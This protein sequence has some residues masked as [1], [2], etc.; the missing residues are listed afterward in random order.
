MLTTVCVNLLF[1]AVFGVLDLAGK[2]P[3]NEFKKIFKCPLNPYWELKV[4]F[5]VL[6]MI[7]FLLVSPIWYITFTNIR[8]GATTFQRYGYLRARSADPHGNFKVTDQM[9]ESFIDSSINNPIVI[10]CR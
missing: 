8:I 10:C 4:V 2:L 5:V 7:V 9:T 1:N 6:V 3:S